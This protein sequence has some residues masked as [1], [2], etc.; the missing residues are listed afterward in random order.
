M[1]GTILSFHPG[2]GGVLRGE[3]GKRYPFEPTAWPGE[4]PP[5]PGTRVDFEK[6]GD[7]A[8]D[9]VPLPDAAA[10]AP[11][12]DIAAWLAARP[13]LPIALLLLVACFL[14]FLTLGPFSANLFNLVGVAS[15]LG[16]YAPVNVN[17][18]TGL[19]LFH[20]L[21]LVPVLA[22]TLAALEWRGL[23][24]RWWRLGIGLA[25]LLGPAA[26]ALGARAL[27]TATTPQGGL[28]ARLVRRAREY[29]S[30][31][32]FVPQIGMGWI[33]IAMLSVVLVVIGIFWRADRPGAPADKKA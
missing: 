15:S 25:G 26:I 6:D 11:A 8:C 33:A 12:T 13:G 22:L 20:G 27:F 31:D 32:L 1:I 23:A 9:L 10:P 29:V 5:V 30:P 16:R 21:Y 18:E 19:W 28:G 3:D 17:M 7:A 14:P 24:G 2:F 4:K